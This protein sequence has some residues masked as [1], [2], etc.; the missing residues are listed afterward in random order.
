MLKI[1]KSLLILITVIFLGIFYRIY[2]SNFDDYWLDE[3]FGFWIS[4]PQLN[5]IESLDRSFGPGRGQNL[6]FDFVLK[7]FYSTITPVVKV[8]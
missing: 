3:Y 2:Q 4:D 1:N 7:Y 5:F 8:D 6:L